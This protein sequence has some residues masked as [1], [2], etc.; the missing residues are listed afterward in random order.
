M[1]TGHLL[2]AASI[3][4]GIAAVR[5]CPPDSNIPLTGAQARP[6]STAEYLVRRQSQCASPDASTLDSEFAQQ[7]P[8]WSEDGIRWILEAEDRER[9]QKQGS[10]AAQSSKNPGSG[11]GDADVPGNVEG[12]QGSPDAGSKRPDPA[13]DD[14]PFDVEEEVRQR[15]QAQNA[16]VGAF[17]LSRR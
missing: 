7:V 10:D 5:P 2:A 12:Q 8:A 9:E 11:A 3:F 13:S 16:A 4:F 6:L 17:T 14:A 1:R 15:E